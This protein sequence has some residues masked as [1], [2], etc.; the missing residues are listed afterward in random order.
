MFSKIL[1]KLID[2][3]IVPAVLLLTVRIVSVVLI[4]YQM[5]I[6]FAVDNTGFIFSTTDQFLRMNSLSVF[7]MSIA[8]GLGL[9]YILVKSMV[10]HSSHIT[11]QTTAKI[12]S[13]KLSFFIQNSYDLY[14]QGIIWLSYTYL[15]IFGA[16][17]MVLSG[18]L[19]SWVFYVSLSIG[20]VGTILFVLDI[21]KEM[22][23]DKATEDLNYYE[24]DE[25]TFVLKFGEDY[26]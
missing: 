2:Q 26:V 7:F 14:S 25:E 13:M 17:M 1:I 6:P 21:E 3:A 20:I 4:S 18:A 22:E 10:F 12:F 5:G 23:I 11:P 19:L 16:G 24:D 8:L 9:A 15:L